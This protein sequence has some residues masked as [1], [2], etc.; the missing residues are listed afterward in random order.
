MSR[1]AALDRTNLRDL[2][3]ELTGA[4]SQ[5]G[6]AARWRCVTPSH[7][8]ANPSTTVFTDSH[9]RE[10]YRC[11]SCGDAGTAIDALIHAR[12]MSVAEAISELESRTNS[13]D[14]P[15]PERS[16]AERQPA[17]A[18]PL[19]N[20]AKTYIEQCAQRL[21]TPEGQPARTWLLQRGLSDPD[22]LRANLVGFDPGRRKLPRAEGLPGNIVF[23]RDGRTRHLDL[24]GGSGVTFPAFDRHGDA[25]HVQCRLLR[26]GRSGFKYVN[27]RRE[28]GTIPAASFPSAP[29]GCDPDLLIV[30]EGTPDGLIGLT[31]GFR[32]ATVTSA[33]TVRQAT[34]DEISAHA[35]GAT[36]VLAFDSDDAGNAA[37]VALYSRL[38][39]PVR[40]LRLP[41]GHDLTETYKRRSTPECHLDTTSRPISTR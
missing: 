28:H 11:W 27:P 13:T 3:T 9:G 36:I 20:D 32:V 33:T 29:D 12:S 10:R 24:P 6:A 2:L 17:T 21:W 8:D 41:A 19:S 35:A 25:A 22:V 5:L 15:A 30:T 26:P 38:S 14:T 7:E 31:A 39:G 16:R 34:A 23:E 4:P 1:D 18:V 40:V 37:A